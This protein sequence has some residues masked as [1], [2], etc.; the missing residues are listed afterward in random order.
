MPA[1]LRRQAESIPTRRPR[2]PR[3]RCAPVAEG[4]EARNLLS[5]MMYQ[6]DRLH[7]AIAN[8]P[9]SAHFVSA[10]VSNPSPLPG[11]RPSDIR[12][13]Y[14]FDAIS[15]TDAQGHAIPGDGRGQTIAIVD[16]YDD[17]NVVADLHT[18]DRQFGLPDPPRFAKVN[19]TGGTTYPQPDD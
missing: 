2:R 18:F 7:P 16:A 9:T 5:S 4:L 19:Q 15:F 14:G 10:G 17:P 8:G 13:A 3:R 1:K 11:Y 12:R 6:Y